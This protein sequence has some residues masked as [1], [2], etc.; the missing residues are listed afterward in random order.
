V[1]A[2]ALLCLACALGG[3]GCGG[4]GDRGAEAARGE[5][6]AEFRVR[7]ETTAGTFVAAF[8]RAWSPRGVDRLHELVRVGFFDDTTFFR[9]LPQIAQF[10]MSGD[11]KVTAK[12][13]DV[14]IPDD[15]AR[16]RNRRGTIAL[17]R[18]PGPDSR[19]THVFVNLRD[20]PMLD[21]GKFPPIGEV[22][23]GMEVVDRL[24]AGYGERPSQQEIA[25]RG[26]AYLEAEWPRLSRIVRAAVVE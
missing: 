16:E 19:T 5:A 25:R 18:T 6:P 15:P 24:Y 17:G 8:H 7:F 14:T 21:D 4:D 3:Y 12:W 2:F 10:G 23:E 1:R 22:V 13:F 20:N 26:D 9:V 11:P